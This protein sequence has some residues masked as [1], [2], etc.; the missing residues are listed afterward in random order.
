MVE[1]EQKSALD[2][3]V[4]RPFHLETIGLLSGGHSVPLENKHNKLAT[5]FPPFFLLDHKSTTSTSPTVM[6]VTSL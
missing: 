1:H 2:V 3:H 6:L 5:T 4:A